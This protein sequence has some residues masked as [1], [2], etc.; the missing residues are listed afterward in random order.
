MGLGIGIGTQ[1]RVRARDRD[2]G[3]GIGIVRRSPTYSPE[4]TKKRA[5]GDMSTWF[6]VRIRLG[7]TGGVRK[8]VSA[9]SSSAGKYE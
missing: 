6:R 2:T 1:L 3:L 9:T 8:S 5:C 7:Y 4:L